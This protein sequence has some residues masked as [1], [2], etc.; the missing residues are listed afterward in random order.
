MAAILSL[1][2]KS[3]V[4]PCF[5]CFFHLVF[6]ADMRMPTT[7]S[8]KSEKKPP[9]SSS[10]KTKAGVVYFSTRQD[11]LSLLQ[12]GGQIGGNN[13]RRRVHIGGHQH[14]RRTNHKRDGNLKV[15][16]HGSKNRRRNH[17]QRRS[18]SLETKKL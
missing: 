16:K 8:A 1:S 11:G 14:Q 4:F 6:L 12:K 17:R 3:F 7:K 15:E 18:E 10:N 5:L 2:E 9:R 13:I